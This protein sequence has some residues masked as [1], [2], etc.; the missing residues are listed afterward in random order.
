MAPGGPCLRAARSGITCMSDF[1]GS[2]AVRLLGRLPLRVAGAL[3]VLTGVAAAPAAAQDIKPCSE[4]VETTKNLPPPDSPPIYRCMELRFHPENSP[5]IDAETYIY[6]LKTNPS[7]VDEKKWVAY[8]EDAIQHDF[9]SLWDTN[10]LE[11]L[12]VEV[13]DEPFTNGVKGEHVIFHMEERSRVKAVDYEGSRKVEISKIEDTL[14]DKG[15]AIRLDNFVDQS[16]IKRV[17]QVIHDLYADEGYEAAEIKTTMIPVEGGPK[18]VRLTFNIDQGPKYR[19]KDIA[20]DGNSAFSDNRLAS[21]MKENKKSNFLSF[22]TGAGKYQ[23]AKFEDDAQNVVDFYQNHG[24]ARARVGSPQVEVIGD[25]KDGKDRY[26]R[27]RVPV[28]EGVRYKIGKFDITGNTAVKAAPLKTVFKIKEGDYFNAKLLRKGM[29]KAK[30]AYGQFGFWEFVPEPELSFRGVDPTTDKPIDGQEQPPILDL[31]VHMNEGKQ[32]FINRITFTGNTTTH[33]DVIRREMRVAEGG[34]FNSE[35]LKDSVKRLNQLGYFK[36]LEKADDIGVTPT[37]GAEGKVDIKLKFAEQNRNQLAFGAG[38]SQIDGFF[39]QLSFQTSNFLGRG[40]TFGVSLQ[41]GSQ[42]KNYQVS[43]SEPYLFERPITIGVDV[44]NRQYIFPLQYTQA[45]TGTNTVLGLPVSNYTRFFMGYSYDKIGVSDINAAYLNPIVLAA[46]P[47]LQDALL[48]DQGGVRRVS[49]VSPSIVYNTVNHPIFPTSGSRLTVG[50]D[51]AGL[52]GNTQFVSSTLE[53]IYYH[54]FNPRMSFGLRGQSQYTRPYGDTTVLPIFQR[55]FLGGEYTIRGFDLRT[56]GPRDATSGVVVG[57]NKTLLFNA[58]YY[59]NIA[60]PVRF[61]FFY[62]AGQVR[63]TGQSFAWHDPITKT[64]NPGGP[65]LFDPLTG[66]GLID[67]N[68]PKPVI[69]TIGQ[70]NAFQTST[71]VE[72]RFF[73]P[74]LNVPF[75]LIAAYNPQRYNIFNNNGQLTPKF[76][77]RFAVGTT[78]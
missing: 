11:N 15:I 46:S 57:G 71:G 77:F 67:P 18:L 21:Q 30:E 2:S 16:T 12:W 56:I 44:F 62:D 42:A 43:F 47:Y 70:A 38:V 63:D 54:S 52:G 3:I 6:Y 50:T 66:V 78:F 19:I 4:T 8:N 48:L 64:T 55:Y 69:T 76:T 53:A 7:V 29:E 28:D 34:V 39:G 25:S 58:E 17:Q 61:L 9:D 14:R 68:A 5:M 73:M 65:I 72:L 10:F 51:I 31:T 13:I 75:R 26:I 20:F 27:L 33:D 60:S 40:E 41:K 37:P 24:Y 1:S 49:K 59:I 22:I 32:F 23:E 74:V 35:A 45:E 36:P